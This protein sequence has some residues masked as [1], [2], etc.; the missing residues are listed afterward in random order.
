MREQDKF[1]DKER[2]IAAV[3]ADL[4]ERNDYREYINFVE[5][6]ESFIKRWVKQK[7]ID[8]CYDEPGARLLDIANETITELC[9]TVRNICIDLDISGKK[10]G[11]FCEWLDQFQ[12]KFYAAC[13]YNATALIG[14]KSFIVTIDYER[15]FEPS[16]DTNRIKKELSSKLSV[17]RLLKAA[18]IAPMIFWTKWL[19]RLILK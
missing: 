8:R 5:N 1:I 2:L 6:Q 14:L 3:L 17:Y 18:K 16:H 11:P 12:E 9:S 10:S 13:R 4:A 15:V 7:V 19:K